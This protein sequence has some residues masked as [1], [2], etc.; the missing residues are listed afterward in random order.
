MRLTLRDE[1]PF[2]TMTLTHHGTTIDVPDVLVDTGSAST[3]LNA[4]LAASVGIVP[5]PS[6]RLR[7]LRGVGGREVVFVRNVNRLAVGERGLD[8]FEVEIGEMDYGFGIGGI[9]G[10]DFLTSAGAILD[11][12]ALTLAF[13]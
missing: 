9:L 13:T 7:T 4:D 2:V 8:Q 1:L 10:M 5:Q 11:L 6:D 12:R 3:I